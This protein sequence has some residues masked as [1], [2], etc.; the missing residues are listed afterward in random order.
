[1]IALQCMFANDNIS[2]M[3]CKAAGY[4]IHGETTATTTE[5]G[6]EQQITWVKR[7][8]MSRREGTPVQER[9]ERELIL[10]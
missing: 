3:E 9:V 10:H 7:R 5:A 2:N 6:E 8:F 1:M 4:I